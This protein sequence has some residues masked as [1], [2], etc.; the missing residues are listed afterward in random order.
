[1]QSQDDTQVTSQLQ[2]GTADGDGSTEEVQV[3]EFELGAETY[4]V[5]IDY[6]SEIV[7]KGS[8]TPVPNAPHYVD[9]VMDLRGRTT[10]IVNP[11]AL[12]NVGSGSESK[13]IIIFDPGTFD[14]EAAVGWVVDEV[15]QVIRVAMSDVEAP[16]LEHDRSIEGVIKRD[17]GLTIWISPVEAMA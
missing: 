3:L 5:D 4:C 2:P 12:L 14:D 10:S 7:D 6:V 1:M 15:Y 11:K 13:R 8:L 16:P 9:G 17:D